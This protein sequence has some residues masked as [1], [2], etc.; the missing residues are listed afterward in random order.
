MFI[1]R[2]V[3]SEVARERKWT[4][5]FTGAGISAPV[6]PTFEENPE[7]RSVLSLGYLNEYYEDFWR[8]VIDMQK[9]CSAAQPTT[10]HRMLAGQDQTR[11]R[12]V[13]MNLDGLHTKA[14]SEHVLEV[15]GNF[16]EVECMR[17]NRKFSFGTVHCKEL[18]CPTCGGK[19][20]P[21]IMLYGDKNIP[22]Y[23]MA[24]KY[25]PMA[26]ELVIVGTS[27]KTNFACEYKLMAEKIGVPIKIFNT[28]ANEELCEY[29]SAQDFS[30][31][32]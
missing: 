16:N 4:V 2:G 11:C 5:F 26:K 25:L 18:Y 15:H 8:K 17:C 6:I 30:E 14:G 9:V 21:K 31:M 12:I 19:M 10:A 29:L 24:T 1:D 22:E 3:S 13:T 32:F 23:Q 27:F 7:M 28:N 20:R